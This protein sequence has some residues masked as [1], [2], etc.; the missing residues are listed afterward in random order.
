MSADWY[1]IRDMLLGQNFVE[2][3]VKEALL[4]AA[5]CSHSDGQKLHALFVN[6]NN[7]SS[8]P[9]T[10]GEAC[11]VFMA[12]K[13]Q[14][15]LFACFAACLTEDGAHDVGLLREASERNCALAQ[16]LF[17]HSIRR[18]HP[19]RP[20]IMFSLASTAAAQDGNAGCSSLRYSN[21][22]MSK[23]ETRMRFWR[24]AFRLVWGVM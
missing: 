16:V 4:L 6:N 12:G 20:Q 9:S 7:A 5:N 3:N 2:Q 17:A 24:I 1:M 10:P 18:G 11:K 21:P 22:L 8:F 23:S 15:P 14:D 13:D 19:N